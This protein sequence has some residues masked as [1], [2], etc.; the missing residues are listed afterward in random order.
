[1]KQKKNNEIIL[2]IL[3][4]MYNGETFIDNCLHSILN[5]QTVEE[6]ILKY[7]EIIIVNDGSTDRGSEKAKEWAQKWNKKIDKEFIQVIDKSNGQ[8]G[9]VINRGLKLA[10]GRYLKVLDVDDIFNTKHLIDVIRII[11]SIRINVDVILTDFIFDKV[12]KNK[13][14]FYKW[15]KYF[16]PYK[17]IEMKNAK[18]PNSIITMHSIVYQTKFLKDIE[19]QQIE[20]IYYS[21]SQYSLIPFT[22]AKLLYYI[23]IPLYR[24]YIGRNEQSINIKTM[25]KNRDHQKLLMNTIFDELFHIKMNSNNQKEYA[26]KV[27]KNMFEWQIL[28][29]TYDHSIKNKSKYIYDLLQDILWKCKE[30]NNSYAYKMINDGFL[31]SLIKITKGN[32][33]I[34]LIRVG[35]KLYAKYKLNI[36]ADWD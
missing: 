22:R 29:A 25:V 5:E 20:G 2:T 11:A 34:P 24:Y 35:E 6:E 27:A 1:M 28:I 7:V 8:Y 30:A 15:N 36:M 23:N 12:N 3:I 17:I 21:D 33:I 14:I 19:Y 18:F 32:G 9:S 16:E 31:S 26:W 13:Q 10:K 4:P